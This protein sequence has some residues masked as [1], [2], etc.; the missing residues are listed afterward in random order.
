MKCLPKV[1]DGGLLEVRP[2][3]LVI[4]DGREAKP[5]VLMV[6]AVSGALAGER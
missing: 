2:G 4:S 6:G 5:R 1:L 3:R